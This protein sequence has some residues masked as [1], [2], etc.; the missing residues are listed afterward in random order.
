MQP[1]PKFTPPE[2]HQSNQFKY[3]TAENQ[4]ITSEM[5]VDESD[6]LQEETHE[7]GKRTQR[8]TKNKLDQRITDVKS[9]QD[10]LNIKLTEMTNE[11]NSLLEFRNRL[12]RALEGTLEPQKVTQQCLIFREKRQGIDLVH[13]TAEVELLKEVDVIDGVQRLLK[14][15]IEQATEQIRRNRSA[16][17]YLSC[18]ISDK[19]TS[20]NIDDSCMSLNNNSNGIKLHPDHIRIEP[21]SVSQQGWRNFS[22]DNINKAECERVA[23]T[24]LRGII[25]SVLKTTCDDLKFQ[26]KQVNLALE[27]RLTETKRAKDKLEDHRDKVVNEISEQKKNISEL[28]KAIEDKLSLM[29]VAQ[30]RLKE[31]AQRPNVELCRDQ[32]QYGLI[33][34]VNEITMNVNR[35]KARVA[36]AER[37]VVRLTRQKRILDEDI[38]VKAN[39]IYLDEV[40]CGQVRSKLNHNLY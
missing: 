3:K 16:M 36:D 13:D 30:T 21:K 20:L 1:P 32:A 15:N 31:R 17:H 34:E 39:T 5:L 10:E 18:D 28:T 6:R 19:G 4:R 25:F 29:M 23:S 14:R 33:D 35:L 8:A 24:S 40:K 12:A 22:N 11:T 9:W 27:D 26:E 37:E 38:A 2:W 7:T